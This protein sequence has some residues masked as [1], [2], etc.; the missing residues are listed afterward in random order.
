MS[1]DHCRVRFS[2]TS[3]NHS[4]F[5]TRQSCQ[6]GEIR[7]PRRRWLSANLVCLAFLDITGRNKRHDGTLG[8]I[9]GTQHIF[10]KSNLYEGPDS[11]AARGAKRLIIQSS[12]KILGLRRIGKAEGLEWLIVER[13]RLAYCDDHP[14]T[15]K[16]LGS[17]AFIL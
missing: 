10:E 16:L 17:L 7:E 5:H 1:L 3:S 9:Y 2:D 14:K 12:D 13:Q 15:M 6:S 11:W 4:L 8:K